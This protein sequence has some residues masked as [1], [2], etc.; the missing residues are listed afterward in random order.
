MSAQEKAVLSECRQRVLSCG[1]PDLDLQG[2]AFKR[3][4]L[5]DGSSG[6]GFYISPQVWAILSDTDLTE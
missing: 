5:S 4:V 3:G 2:W 6:D 1:G